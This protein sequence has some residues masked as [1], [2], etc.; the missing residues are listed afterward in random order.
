LAKSKKIVL[1]TK[2]DNRKQKISFNKDGS[3]TITDGKGGILVIGGD[4]VMK[5]I[6]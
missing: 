5:K 6:G 2:F 1:H 4:G 3:I